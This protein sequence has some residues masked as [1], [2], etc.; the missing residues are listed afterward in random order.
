MIIKKVYILANTVYSIDT[1]RP[2][3]FCKNLL[4]VNYGLIQYTFKHG[5]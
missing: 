1:T 4:I 3:A 2:T 5:G